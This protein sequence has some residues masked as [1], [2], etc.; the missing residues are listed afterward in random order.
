M[1][2]IEISRVRPIVAHDILGKYSLSGI[3]KAIALK[4][5]G[6]TINI[7]MDTTPWTPSRRTGL[8][9]KI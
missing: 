8:M 5:T 2:L 3:F 7:S 1:K 9:A 4:I 6:T